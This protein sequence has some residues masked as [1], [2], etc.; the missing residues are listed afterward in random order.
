MKMKC[1]EMKMKWKEKWTEFNY[2]PQEIDLHFMCTHRAFHFRF[3]FAFFIFLSGE[4][5][6][7]QKNS[8]KKKNPL[9]TV[10]T[11]GNSCSILNV[12]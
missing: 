6:G 2:N 8:I 4:Q 9:K 11:K 5:R 1:K 10:E 12:R 7:N 3:G